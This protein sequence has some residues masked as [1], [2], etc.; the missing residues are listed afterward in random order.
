M[1]CSVSSVVMSEK[2]TTDAIKMQKPDREEGE[3]HNALNAPPLF[4]RGFLHTPAISSPPS[5]NSGLLLLPIFAQYAVRC[6]QP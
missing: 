4:M 1:L 5:E 6:E 3:T 2:S